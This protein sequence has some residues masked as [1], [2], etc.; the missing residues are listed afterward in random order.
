MDRC[1]DHALSD[2]QF[3]FVQGRG[4]DMV[5]AVAHDVGAY[6]VAKGSSTFYARLD[7][8]GAFDLLP[9]CVILEKCADVLPNNLWLLLHNCY[10]SMHTQIK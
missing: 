7:A 4:T 9:H 2:A 8:E 6:C 5:T 3:G 1:K 10:S